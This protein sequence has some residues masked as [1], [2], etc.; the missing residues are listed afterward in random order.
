ME[1]LF[2][3]NKEVRL[4]DNGFVCITDIFKI[5][6]FPESYSPWHWKTSTHGKNVIASYMA[7]DERA[8]DLVETSRNGT[9]VHPLLAIDYAGWIARHDDDCR[10]E[11]SVSNAVDDAGL[12]ENCVIGA[13]TTFKD[14][15]D[16]KSDT[17]PDVVVAEGFGE[18]P[19]DCRVL[20][21]PEDGNFRFD[22]SDLIAVTLE[23]LG[24]SMSVLERARLIRD[25]IAVG[26]GYH[27]PITVSR[28]VTTH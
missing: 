5:S 9:F 2:I 16:G 27:V 12:L 3:R 14:F 20:P 4:N 8:A 23:S 11:D 6:G 25:L 22:P 13:E 24:E 17:P 15:V 26:T 7:D 1:P 19:D 18:E 21:L 28:D 10:L